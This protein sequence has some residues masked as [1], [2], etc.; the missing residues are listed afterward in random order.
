[1]DA[2]RYT[3]VLILAGLLATACTNNS[4]D[5]ANPCVLGDTSC[6]P[7]STASNSTL[8]EYMAS[9][10]TTSDN[11]AAAIPKTIFV[12]TT[13]TNGNMGGISGA[14]SI[15]ASDA[16]GLSLTGTYKAMIVG[17]VTTIRTASATANAGDGQVDWVL[18]AD[19]DYIRQDST[20][21]GTTASTGLF[22]FPLTNSFASSSLNFYTGLNTDWTSGTAPASELCDFG[23][24][25]W[26]DTSSFGAYGDSALTTATTL[27]IGNNACTNTRH[28]LCVEQ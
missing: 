3:K 9:S 24:G 23:S 10:S 18:A 28:L 22:A 16:T 12:S 25:S 26:T 11:T 7:E 6:S 19:T 5:A 14:D 1:M 2:F 20:V 21:I 8:F 4:T 15:C 17:T 27:R 13:T